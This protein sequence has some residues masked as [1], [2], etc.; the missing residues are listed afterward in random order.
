MALTNGGG[1][2]I[3]YELRGNVAGPAL[4]MI[5]GFGRIALHWGAVLNQLERDFY[6]VLLDNRG[7]GRSGPARLPF[8]IAD[9]A[10]DVTRVLDAAGIARAHVLG[11][12]LG[13]MVALRFAIDHGGRLDRLALVCTTAGGRISVPPPIAPFAAMARAKLRPLAESVAV[14]AKVVLGAQFTAENPAIVEEWTRIAERY[15]IP[16]RTL[17][18]QA[19]AGKLHDASRELDR[20]GAPTLVISCEADGLIPPENS[21]VL[22][23]AIRG[24]ELSWLAGDAHDLTT[25]H[26]AASSALIRE[27][28]LRP[29]R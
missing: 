17:V 4:V 7:A 16:L 15:P 24:A 22:A 20:I 29:Q 6:L 8:A 14:E 21:R 1:P 18:Y 26:P 13:G 28:L 19:I 5:R 2:R 25:T 11:M 9:L 12:S 27:F 10:D 23:R 3:F